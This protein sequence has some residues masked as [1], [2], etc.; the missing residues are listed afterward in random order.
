MSAAGRPSIGLGLSGKTSTREI[1]DGVF[2]A[3]AWHRDGRTGVRRQMTATGT[4]AAEAER[5]LD[6]KLAVKSELA[7][8]EKLTPESTIEQLAAIYL[9]RLR[10]SELAVQSKSR[11]AHTVTHTV[12]PGL[13][14]VKMRELTTGSIVRLLNATKKKSAAEARTVRVVLTAMCG[15]AVEDDALKRNVAWKTGAKITG[16]AKR[17]TRA[18]TLED[19]RVVFE[20]IESDAAEDRPGRK[21]RK[22]H[23]DLHDILLTQIGAGGLR[24]SEAAAIQA[25]DIEWTT[26]P[27]TLR[28]HQAVIYQPPVDGARGSYTVQAYTKKKDIAIVPLAKY[29]VDI[30]ARRSHDPGSDGLLFHTAEGSPLNLNNLRRTLRGSLAGSGYEWVSTHT[31]RRTVGT[32]AARDI[33]LG[34]AGASKVLRHRHQATTE[35]S[36]VEREQLAPD[37]TRLTAPFGELSAT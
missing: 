11:Y 27:P 9:E 33:Q 14:G 19:A 12:L 23:D 28:V 26:S 3:S 16:Q 5:K 35:K 17:P 36:Y 10:E 15:L 4:T 6:S 31:M 7:G 1:K 24:V 29:A 25:A 21:S 34:L 13:K 18:L 20:L 2:R 37:V 8:A 32:L 30:L 22:S